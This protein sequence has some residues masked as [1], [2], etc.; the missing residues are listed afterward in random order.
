MPEAIIIDFSDRG[1]DEMYD[2]IK[3]GGSTRILGH[4]M[5]APASNYFFAFSHL[6]KISIANLFLSLTKGFISLYSFTT[7]DFR[8]KLSHYIYAY[9]YHYHPHR[10]CKIIFPE[11]ELC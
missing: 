3:E 5:R 10:L 4:L 1:S 9:L 7:L 6:R 8:N 2:A 11:R